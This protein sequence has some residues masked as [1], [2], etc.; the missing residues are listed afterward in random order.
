MQQINLTQHIALGQNPVGQSFLYQQNH[1][2]G[3]IIIDDV[4]A[5]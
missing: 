3:G 2:N 4:N 5:G 1:R